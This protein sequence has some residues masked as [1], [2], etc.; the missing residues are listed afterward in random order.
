MLKKPT[1]AA[2]IRQHPSKTPLWVSESASRAGLHITP[3]YVSNVRHADAAARDP[4]KM[5]RAETPKQRA[6]RL[7][8]KA[9]R[10]MKNAKIDKSFAKEG[11]LLPKGKKPPQPPLT[12]KMSDL[13][14]D[15]KWNAR[16]LLTDPLPRTAPPTPGDGLVKAFKCI[17]IALGLS[18]ARKLLTETEDEVARVFGRPP[19]VN[20]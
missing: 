6:A 7:R 12:V 18:N 19:I 16:S 20:G 11:I 15:Q 14:I 2:F 1:K 10:D 8:K 3:G 13:D 9:M 4:E 17:A 5:M